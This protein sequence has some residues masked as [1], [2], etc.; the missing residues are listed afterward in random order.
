MVEGEGGGDCNR[1]RSLKIYL[2]GT[3]YT[4][5]VRS[6]RWCRWRGRTGRGG[7]YLELRSGWLE[8]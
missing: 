3:Y 5:G 4:R 8:R 2:V 1:S 7:G 6:R